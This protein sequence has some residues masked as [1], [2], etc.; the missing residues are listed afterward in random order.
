MLKTIDEKVE[1]II[2]RLEFLIGLEFIHRDEI[3]ACNLA[4]QVLRDFKVKKK[5][6]HKTEI[7]SPL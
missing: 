5:Q 6:T 3:G 4:V 2:D 7:L 1:Y